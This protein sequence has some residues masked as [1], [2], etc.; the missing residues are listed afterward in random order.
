MWLGETKWQSHWFAGAN[1]TAE[2]RRPWVS[3]D[4]SGAHISANPQTTNPLSITQQ[5]VDRSEYKV[6]QT[7]YKT[8]GLAL[9]T[10]SYTGYHRIA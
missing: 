2:L 1:T 3:S 8:V 4:E 9:F 5:Y 10:I 6:S 7:R